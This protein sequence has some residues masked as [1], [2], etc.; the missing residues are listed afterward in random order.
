MFRCAELPFLI[1]FFLMFSNDKPVDWLLDYLVQTKACNLDKDSVSQQNFQS[2]Q[3]LCLLSTLPLIPILINV[4]VL[5]YI[6]A[7]SS[8]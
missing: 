3:S 6:T 2:Y 8:Y 7:S 1:Q 5:T 4:K